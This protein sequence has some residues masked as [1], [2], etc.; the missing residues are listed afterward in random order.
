MPE[1]RE[2][3]PF[4]Y[5]KERIY[6][7]D[8]SLKENE[9]TKG[10]STETIS[11]NSAEAAAML[12]KRG[13]NSVTNYIFEPEMSVGRESDV[14]TT[15]NVPLWTVIQR[16]QQATILDLPLIL[17]G[18][19]DREEDIFVPVTVHAAL[20]G[21]EDSKLKNVKDIDPSVITG[22]E[23]NS[24]YTASPDQSCHGD[25]RSSQLIFEDEFGPVV[26]LSEGQCVKENIASFVDMINMPYVGEIISDVQ[27]RCV[28]GMCDNGKTVEVELAESLWRYSRSECDVYKG[29]YGVEMV[30]WFVPTHLMIMKYVNISSSR[31]MDDYLKGV[32]GI[33]DKMKGAPIFLSKPHFLNR[34]HY[35]SQ[36]KG[37][38]DPVEHIHDAFVEFDPLT[39]SIF[40]I[41]KNL[42]INIELKEVS[43][44]GMTTKLPKAMLPLVWK[45]QITN[46]DPHVLRA[47][48]STVYEG[49]YRSYLFSQYSY[50]AAFLIFVTLVC[51]TL[52]T[53]LYSPLVTARERREERLSLFNEQYQ[54][55]YSSFPTYVG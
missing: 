2:L 12:K 43:G 23:M 3:G 22:F 55:A 36:I 19:A 9:E 32:F 42:Q 44:V 39:G 17:L 46:I 7:N 13:L 53:V 18:L 29:E 24:N 51:A 50:G 37:M 4:V 5:R 31:Y 45:K 25:L 27:R 40:K 49:V 47:W 41:V 48:S 52:Y 54:R 38:A 6:N 11:E 33:S 34:R 35:L 16:I 10:F 1:V 8:C 28:N 30:R 26:D 14:V 20:W 21:Y 15:V